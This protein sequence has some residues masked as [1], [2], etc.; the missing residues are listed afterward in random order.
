MKIGKKLNPLKKLKKLKKLAKNIVNPQQM[1]KN[2]M[3]PGLKE[4]QA[5][6]G[7]KLPGIS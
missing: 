2:L 1:R 7:G 6:T 4:V 3:P 5:L